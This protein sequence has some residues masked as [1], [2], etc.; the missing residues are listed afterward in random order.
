MGIYDI[1]NIGELIKDNSYIKYSQFLFNGN[2]EK[3]TDERLMADYIYVLLKGND[4]NTINKPIIYESNI[5]VPAA[6]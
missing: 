2:V 4:L 3:S 5:R 6:I 1:N